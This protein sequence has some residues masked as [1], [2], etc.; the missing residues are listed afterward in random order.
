M[1]SSL[2][3]RLL[4]GFF[5]VIGVVLLTSAITL[6][7]FVARSNLASRL[8][9]RSTAARLLQQPVFELNRP[10]LFDEVVA[11]VDENT[12]FRTVIIDSAS[13]P[14]ASPTAQFS[15]HWG[16]AAGLDSGGWGSA[17]ALVAAGAADQSIGGVAT[18]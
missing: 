14:T 3:S 17:G 1:F 10:G 4:L 16:A 18:R 5:V 9:L 13:E 2:R 12:G 11:R 7:L 8:E 6:L 15:H